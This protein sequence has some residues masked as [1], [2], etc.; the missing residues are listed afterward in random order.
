MNAKYGTARVSD[1]SA[2]ERCLPPMIRLHP[3]PM[4]LD[5]STSPAW[6]TPKSPNL[7]LVYI[8]NCWAPE[9][10]RRPRVLE[11]KTCLHC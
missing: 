2:Q 5:P 8:A 4:L 11:S 7:N 6:P 10:V 1:F 3:E 9:R